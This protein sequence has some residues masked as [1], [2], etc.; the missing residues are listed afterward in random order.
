MYVPDNYDA[1]AKFDAE[2]TEEMERLPVCDLYN[3]TID[4]EFYFEIEGEIFCEDCLNE[5]F[6]KSV[7]DY[8]S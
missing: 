4:D 1:W 8:A 5:V 3:K 7:E 2:Q 6:R